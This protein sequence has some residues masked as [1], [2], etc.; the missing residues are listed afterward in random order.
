MV[1]CYITPV[2]KLRQQWAAHSVDN[3]T[4]LKG[5]VGTGIVWNRA[6]QT[7]TGDK[8]L[9]LCRIIVILGLWQGGEAYKCSS[10]ADHL[11]TNFLEV[12]AT[13]VSACPPDNSSGTFTPEVAVV[14]RYDSLESWQAI[15]YVLIDLAP[16]MV[17]L[18]LLIL[19]NA[20]LAAGPAQ[21]FLFFYQTLPAAVP[22]DI[23]I[24]FRLIA[25]GLWW[26][27][28]TMQS[29]INDLLSSRLIPGDYRLF[30]RI[31]PYITLQYCKLAAVLVVA[32]MALL[33]VKCVHCPCASWRHPWAKLRRSVR[34]FR[35]RRASK[36]TVLNGLCSMAILTYGFVIQQSFSVLQPAKYCGNGTLLS[37]DANVIKSCPFYCRELEYLDTDH[38]PYFAV[39]VIMLLLSL[40]LPLLL[41]YYPAVPALMKRITDRSIPISCHKLAPVFDVF[42]S[43]YKPNLRFFAAFPLLYRIL[44]WLILST[45]SGVVEASA[46]QV[47][48]TFAFIIFLAI[49]SLVQPY[50]KRVHNYIETLY[51][52]N[53]VILSITILSFFTFA[54]PR[55]LGVIGLVGFFSANAVLVNLPIVVGTVCL[56]WKCKRSQR[57]RPSCCKKR[58]IITESVE[59]AKVRSVEMVPSDVYLDVDEVEKSIQE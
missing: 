24:N 51:L 52:V 47:I 48:I 53:L 27:F 13:H 28:F 15:V 54:N 6:D 59:E 3:C 19:F 55:V 35:E 42:Q 12:D 1:L 30:P 14:L 31:L 22:I 20:N 34:H 49:H 39:A 18:P 21:S 26:G 45:M 17:Y 44:I 46:R 58:K 2:I 29:P 7:M 57:C 25:G 37:P 4:T 33:L 9:F 56:L 10:R 16:L 36:G 50:Q 23:F 41:L 43:S 8:M 32:I 38:R 40:P 5:V 11:F